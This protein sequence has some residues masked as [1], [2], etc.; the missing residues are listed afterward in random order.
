MDQTRAARLARGR[1]FE[2]VPMHRNLLQYRTLLADADMAPTSATSAG[3]WFAESA[4]H[5]QASNRRLASFDAGHCPS[6]SWKC[7]ASAVCHCRQTARPQA[8]TRAALNSPP[9]SNPVP[10]DKNARAAARIQSS[11]LG[12]LASIWQREHEPY[13][14]AEFQS[15]GARACRSIGGYPSVSGSELARLHQLVN[16]AAQSQIA[17]SRS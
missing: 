17:R 6:S 5:A 1:E 13:G 2:H 7:I 15:R 4:S 11:I 3:R 8:S 10:L 9:G 12:R 14:R 16:F